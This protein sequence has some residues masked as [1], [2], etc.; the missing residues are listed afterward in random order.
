MKNSWRVVAEIKQRSGISKLT[1]FSQ[2]LN[3]KLKPFIDS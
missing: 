3:L 1:P 2:V